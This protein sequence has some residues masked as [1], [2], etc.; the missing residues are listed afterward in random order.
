MGGRRFCAVVGSRHLPQSRAGHVGQVVNSLLANGWGISSGGAIGADLYALQAVVQVEAAARMR[1]FLPAQ[2]ADAP[3]AV[4]PTLRRFVTRG[5]HVVPGTLYGNPDRR[6]YIRAL[7]RRTA[8]MVDQSQAVVAY[9]AAGKSHGTLF[10]ICQAVR[11]GIPVTVFAVG[12][13]RLPQPR[14]VAGRWEQVASQGIWKGAWK[15]VC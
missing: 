13:V 6:T 7:F 10:T 2:V 12:K 1:V 14:G 3:P 15:W 9:L 4:Q 5:G 11:R 8:T